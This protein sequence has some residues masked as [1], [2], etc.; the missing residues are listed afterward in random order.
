[1]ANKMHYKQWAEE[2]DGVGRAK[3]FP[4]WDGDGTVKIVITNAKMEPASD[5]LV[6]KVKDYIDPDPGKGEGQAPIG[7][8]VTVESAVY[9]KVDI[10]VTVVPEP[11][12]SIED[13]Q[14]EIEEKVKSFFKEI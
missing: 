11:D 12:Y 4:L 3:V 14:K 7:A 6:D 13:A 1:S 9:K 8:T 10:E 5:T 2:V